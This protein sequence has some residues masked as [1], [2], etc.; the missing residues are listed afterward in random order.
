M[1]KHILVLFD[2]SSELDNV[3]DEQACLMAGE[4]IE[5]K[6]YEVPVDGSQYHRVLELTKELRS[7]LGHSIG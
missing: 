6:I 5:E 3:D 4:D 2:V 1:A 7:L